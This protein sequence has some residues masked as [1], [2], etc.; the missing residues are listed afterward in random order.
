M[1]PYDVLKAAFDQIKHPYARMRLSNIY[2]AALAS[3]VN[4]KYMWKTRLINDVYT[5]HPRVFRVTL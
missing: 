5:V 2:S 3:F 1:T 4:A